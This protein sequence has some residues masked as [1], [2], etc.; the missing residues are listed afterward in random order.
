MSGAIDFLDDLFSDIDDVIRGT[1]S[2]I[3]DLAHFSRTLDLDHLE[4]STRTYFRDVVATT[5]APIFKLLG[6]TDETVYSTAL[7]SSQLALSNGGYFQNVVLNAVQNELNLAEE[8]TYAILTGPKKT[9]LRFYTEA[10]RFTSGGNSVVPEVT[11]TETFANLSVVDPI[12]TS[13]TGEPIVVNSIFYAVLDVED[14]LAREMVAKQYLYDNDPTYIF[15]SNLYPAFGTHWGFYGTTLNGGK[16]AFTIQL[17]ITGGVVFI[18]VESQKDVYLDGG[19]EYTDSYVITRSRYWTATSFDGGVEV[20]TDIVSGPVTTEVTT[21]GGPYAN[22]I[23]VELHSLDVIADQEVIINY[24]D[25][26]TPVEVPIANSIEEVYIVSYAL[27]SN[28]TD[29]RYWTYYV[30]TGVYPDLDKE[31]IGGDTDNLEAYPVITLRE[32]FVN[33]DNDEESDAYKTAVRLF[34]YIN[35]FDLA[36]ILE[37]LEANPD[38]ANIQDAFLYHGLNLYTEDKDSLFY[39]FGF[40][41]LLSNLP[42]FTKA[43]WL[44]LPVIERAAAIF[45]LALDQKD[46]RFNTAITATY[47]EVTETVG[48]IGEVGHMEREVILHPDSTV[49]FNHFTYKFEMYD[50]ATGTMVDT[51]LHASQVSNVQGYTNSVYIIRGQMNPTTYGTIEIGSLYSS[52]YILEV[53]TKVNVATI[54]LVNPNTI[55]DSEITT[56]NNFL[57]PIVAYLIRQIPHLKCERIL[58]DSMHIVIYAEQSIHLEYYETSSFIKAVAIIIKVVALIIFIFSGGFAGGVSSAL[59]EIGKQLLVQFLLRYAI[60]KIVQSN[61]SDGA[62][63]AAILL[64]LY[65]GGDLSEFVGADWGTLDT[66]LF[67]IDSVKMALQYDLYIKTEDLLKE[68]E[69]FGELVKSKQEQLKLAKEFLD[70]DYSLDIFL[71][72][73]SRTVPVFDTTMDAETFF[74]KSL[75]TNLAPLI[76]SQPSTYVASVLNLDNIDLN[77]QN[78]T[79]ESQTGDYVTIY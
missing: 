23:L 29:V 60:S 28:Q 6:I 74:Q 5:F 9:S 47:M 70:D 48:V 7:F 77:S 24:P 17:F 72:L 20:Y 19:I 63:A 39:I 41:L 34:K 27:V 79:G 71:L 38:K 57:I 22:N 18:T 10:T 59:L 53:G 36:Y 32:E 62:K 78:T 76:T 43:D 58:T 52:S 46:G 45:A 13:L 75:L 42:R 51:G 12:L 35:N 1:L 55:V 69:E 64:V 8:A 61:L 54:P 37:E 56:K 73:N 33:I 25:N 15:D 11:V 2:L 50:V 14:P 44:A 65:Y 68:K 21:T 30:E 4:E 31:S 67:A 49:A 40:F 16:T 26:V 66:I 3:D